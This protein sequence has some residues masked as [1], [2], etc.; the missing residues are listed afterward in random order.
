MRLFLNPG[1]RRA[2][3]CPGMLSNEPSRIKHGTLWFYA[4]PLLSS[5]EPCMHATTPGLTPP[6]AN[7]IKPTIVTPFASVCLCDKIAW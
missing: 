2:T 4:A 7:D 1:E 5:M 3:P 6:P